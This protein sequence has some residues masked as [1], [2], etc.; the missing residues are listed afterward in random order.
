MSKQK[1]PWIVLRPRSQGKS[2][3]FDQQLVG[4]GKRIAKLLSSKKAKGNDFVLAT[5]DDFLG[6]VYALILALHNDPPFKH[7]PRGQRI[8]P[9]AVL[10]RARSISQAH[11]VRTT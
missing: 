4:L 1:A 5:L 3:R 8:D 11:R 2:F 9:R 10:K 7:R 6:A